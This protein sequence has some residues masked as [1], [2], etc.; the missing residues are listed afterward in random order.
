[1]YYKS[2]DNKIVR[3]VRTAEGEFTLLSNGVVK[4][5]DGTGKDINDLL[6]TPLIVDGQPGNVFQ[7]IGDILYV[8]ALKKD[9]FVSEDML[10]T[11]DGEPAHHSL[12][13]LV[14]V[15]WRTWTRVWDREIG[16]GGLTAMS[17]TD[18]AI[19]VAGFREYKEKADVCTIVAQVDLSGELT[20]LQHIEAASV[21]H[22]TEIV[23]NPTTLTIF[24]DSFNLYQGRNTRFQMEL[25]HG[26][27][28]I[29]IKT[30]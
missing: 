4:K 8:A 12:A 28:V 29:D 18:E 2:T 17:V 19:Y 16:L 21:P 14:A 27:H 9:Q 10:D 24:V 11:D 25:D 3:R 1:M 30:L 7:V 23:V 13:Y 6:D 22:P 15:D 26:G 20:W 5:P